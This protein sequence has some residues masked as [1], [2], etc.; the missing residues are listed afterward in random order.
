VLALPVSFTGMRSL[1]DW[2]VWWHQSDHPVKQLDK[3]YKNKTKVKMKNKKKNSVA[4][5]S[6]NLTV[7]NLI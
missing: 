2:D 5:F 1:L 6:V 3:S 7:L 4:S